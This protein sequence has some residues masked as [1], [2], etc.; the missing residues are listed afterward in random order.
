M[1]VGEAE[2]GVLM[3]DVGEAEGGVLMVDECRV[4][5]VVGDS[6]HGWCSLVGW[7]S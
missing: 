1:D 5:V 4:D 2:G 3:V 7:A 6:R